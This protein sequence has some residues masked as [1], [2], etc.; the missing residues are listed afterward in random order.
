MSAS[1]QCVVAAARLSTDDRCTSDHWWAD[2]YVPMSNQYE[3]NRDQLTPHTI[4]TKASVLSPTPR[5]PNQYTAIDWGP[6]YQSE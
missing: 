6:D 1:G 3:N 4:G 5:D 2:H